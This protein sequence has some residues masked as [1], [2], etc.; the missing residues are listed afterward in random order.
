MA[1]TSETLESLLVVVTEL[2][3]TLTATL[4]AKNLP[5]PSF[6][7]DAPG[8]LPP[9]QDIQG[10]RTKLVGALMDMLHLA[11]GPNEYFITQNM[12]VS[13]INSYIL[14]TFFFHCTDVMNPSWVMRPWH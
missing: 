7:E 8:S 10:P 12:W 13:A 11:M 2:T 14:S 4:R 6:N 9:D 3:T 5:E 1:Q